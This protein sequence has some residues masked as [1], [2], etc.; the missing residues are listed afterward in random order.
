MGVFV[1]TDY[2]SLNKYNEELCGDKVEV[3]RSDDSVTIVLADGLGSGVKANILSTLTSKIAATMFSL[4]SNIDDVVQTIAD[5]LPVSKERSAAYSTFSILQIYESGEAYLAEYDNPKTIFFSNGTY[6]KL[7]RIER[8]INGK[9]VK[10]CRFNVASQDFLLMISDGVIHAGVGHSLKFGWKWINVK[11]FLKKIYKKEDTAKNISMAIIQKCKRLYE[12]K[13]G[14]DTTV[15]S[16][17]VR[18]CEQINIII[19]PPTD[20]SMDNYVVDKFLNERGKK[21]VCGGTTSKIISRETGKKIITNLDYI[22]KTI[23]PAAKIEGIDLTTE[24]ILTVNRV[25]EYVEK[26]CMGKNSMENCTYINGNDAASKLARLLIEESTM[27]HFFVGRAINPAHQNP[28]FPLN[29]GMKLKIVDDLGK[30]LEKLG[31]KVIIE[32]F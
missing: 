10:E 4:G 3:I 15:V 14:D 9:T 26:Y 6:K 17:K 7:N 29:F 13:P 18:N 24:G 16:I 25:L 31:K 2:I 5:T 1:E 22:D 32:Y 20:K 30:S 11:R 23:P 19:G 21:V 8:V 28:D 27:V 12:N